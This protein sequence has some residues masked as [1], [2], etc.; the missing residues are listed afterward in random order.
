MRPA[1]GHCHILTTLVLAPRIDHSADGIFSLARVPT[2]P[3]RP[4]PQ[5]TRL[6]DERS[7]VQTKRCGWLMSGGQ[8]PAI[9]HAGVFVP[10][11][12]AGATA[13][14]TRHRYSALPD[15]EIPPAPHRRQ[16]VVQDQ[17]VA[18]SAA[19]RRRRQ[20]SAP[21]LSVRW[22]HL[23]LRELSVPRVIS[24]PLGQGRSAGRRI[25]GSCTT[26]A[27]AALLPVEARPRRIV[28]RVR[29]RSQRLAAMSPPPAHAPPPSPSTTSSGPRR[30]QQRPKVRIN[31]WCPRC[32]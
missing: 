30:F 26:A 4:Q 23:A 3:G 19:A 10:P 15:A 13:W 5:G 7:K 9:R 24:G 12:A 31:W 21:I 22:S 18:G 2:G 32:R 11:H 17:L 28:H 29:A 25:V 27:G 1:A 20:R 16:A 8:V 6:D 14:T